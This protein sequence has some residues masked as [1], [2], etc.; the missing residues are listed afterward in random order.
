MSLGGGAG[1]RV[2]QCI[3]LHPSLIC[4]YSPPFSSFLFSPP[5]IFNIIRLRQ[6]WYLFSNIWKCHM[7]D[8]LDEGCL[9]PRGD[10]RT[11]FAEATGRQFSPYS[12]HNFHRAVQ[13]W[14]EVLSNL[15]SFWSFWFIASMETCTVSNSLH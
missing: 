13:I 9:A 1:S 5:L 8:R 10:V 4:A 3:R 12:E 6:T 2:F 14:E 7:E 15:K 11:D